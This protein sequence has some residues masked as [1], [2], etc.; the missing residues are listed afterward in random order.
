M[1]LQ[2]YLPRLGT[3]RKLPGPQ[4]VATKD[5]IWTMHLGQQN[6]RIS[7]PPPPRT[8]GFVASDGSMLLLKL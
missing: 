7:S 5:K 1:D 4:P 6:Q 8:N 2:S 3:R